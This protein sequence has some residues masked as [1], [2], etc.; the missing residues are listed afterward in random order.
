MPASVSPVLVALARPADYVDF[1]P[2]L[3]GEDALRDTASWELIRDDGQE[4]IGALD[5]PEEYERVAAKAVAAELISPTWPSRR[6]VARSGLDQP[7]SPSVH[8]LSPTPVARPAM[9]AKKELADLDE[10]IQ[11]VR[12]SLPRLKPWQR[13]LQRAP[14]DRRRADPDRSDERPPW[15]RTGR[16]SAGDPG[17]GKACSRPQLPKSQPDERT[18][19]LR[20]RS[21]WLLT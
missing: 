8:A 21:G 3:V 14:G 9:L 20:C 2:R 13:Q 1:H 11:A 5:R 12:A 4:V 16:D 10:L 6:V 7:G 17:R 19:A 18:M 15:S